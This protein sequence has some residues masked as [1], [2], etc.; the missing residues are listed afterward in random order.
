MFSTHKTILE[1]LLSDQ[2]WPKSST[3][4]EMKM[5]N[6]VGQD[7]LILEYNDMTRLTVTEHPRLV[8]ETWNK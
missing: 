1:F 3:V 6:R 5:K 4:P 8:R 2:S 7:S